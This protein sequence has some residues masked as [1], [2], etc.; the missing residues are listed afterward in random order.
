MAVP[1]SNVV[2]RIV[3]APSG[4]GPYA[5]TFE[6]LAAT[7]IEVYKGDTLL[8][9]TT[10]YT[11]T[12]NLNGTGEVT[13]VATAGTDNITIVGA[14]TIQRTTD[15]V[16]GGDLFANSLNEELDSLTIFTQQ[17][18]E[19]GDRSIRAPVTDPTNIDMTLPTRTDRAGKY[20]SFN[21][22]TGDPEVVNNVVDITAVA[23][24]AA[25][26]NTVAGQISPVNNISTVAGAAANISTV[27]GIAA[28]VTTVA[29]ISGN[30][31]TVAGVSADVTAV[32]GDA[33][34][35]GAVAAISADVQALGPIAAD[36][37]TV[38]GI[39]S[40][41]TAV[42]ADATDIGT[43]AGN[44][45]NVNTVAGISANVTTVAGDSADIQTV[46]GIDSDITTVAGIAAN[47]TTVAGISA[48][49]TTVAGISADVTTVATNVTDITNFSDVYLGPAATDPATRND[50][51]ALQ[52]GDL[53]FN[54][55]DDAI[56]VYTGSAWVTAYITADGFVTVADAQTITG[57]KT[58]D[59]GLNTDTISEETSAA[60]VTVDGVI[61]KDSQV[62]TDQINEKTSAAGVTIDGVLLKDG[63]A[64]FTS[65]IVVTE[66]IHPVAS[67]S[68][69]SALASP[70][71]A[72]DASEGRLINAHRNMKRCLLLDNGT[73][74][75][76]LNPTNSA[77]K[78]DGTAS[79]LTGADGMVM[80]QIPKFYVRRQVAG[81]I[82]TWSVADTAL[83]GFVVHPA[84]IK[85]GVEVDFRYYSAYDACAFDTSGST[86]ISGLNR[87]N[88]VSNTPNVD[89]TASTGDVLASVSGVHPMVGLTRAQFRTIAA[90]RGSGWRQLDWTLFSA[91]QVLYLTEY[92]TFFSQSRLGD[93]NTNGTYVTQ[94]GDQNDSPNSPAGLTNSIG[95]ASTNGSQASAGAKPGTAFMSYRGIENFYGNVWNWADGCIVN[96]DGAVSAN[97]ARMWWTN[98]SADFSD[99][100]KT[101]MTE[102]A[103]NLTTGGDFAVALAATD[104]FFVATNVS[105]GSASTYITDGYFGSTSDDRVVR[106]GGGAARGA[107]AGAF[108]VVANDASSGALRDVGAR[109]AF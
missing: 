7:D 88:A 5:F 87:D 52:A 99:S 65:P 73:V 94:S 38:A 80:V 57:V 106:V 3:F 42:A 104:Y 27:A 101:N 69:N 48:N 77:L 84:F 61:L 30:V 36:I 35:I 54:T 51:S 10:D 107:N 34:D 26:I 29:G 19:A 82:T 103:V 13:L 105:G 92:Q 53:Y 109:L 59:N 60:G 45:A 17:N 108:L 2:R 89:A 74:N 91:V 81:T 55:A 15:F 67:F 22:S 20:L 11:V 79:V 75:Y 23:N 14:R 32:A 72:F 76:F 9:L 95:N 97:Q 44:I 47:V 25:N 64:T 21:S 93:G 50:S 46:A 78:A 28:N 68:W 6:I 96:P 62:S 56:K 40:D 70:A 71:A 58:F 41:V 33:T 98:N 12:I 100:V 39:D 90:N 49:V 31:T 37:T 102:I 85:D 1:I 18:A 83:P 86:F 43:V 16:T 24:N 4:V 66:L 63:G 8:T